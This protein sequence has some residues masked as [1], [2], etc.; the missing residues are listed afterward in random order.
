MKA[1]W[2]RK[3]LGELLQKT[4][5]TDPT[6]E[7]EKPFS[8]ID[9]SSVSNETFSITET[10]ELLGK[11][12]PSRARRIVRSGDVIF[13]T[14]RP[15]LKR[16]AIVPDE[17]DNAV[18]STGYFVL[19]GGSKIDNGYLFYWLFSDEFQ[20]E[21]ESRQKGASYPAVNDGDIRD[22]YV[23]VPPLNEQRR[24]VAV[25][26][27]AFA[28][29]ATAT[30]NAQ[31]NLT[32]ARA[33]FESYLESIFSNKDE[34]W[35]VGSLKKI[36]G[37]VSTGPFGSLLHK[38]DYVENGIPLVNPAHIVGEFIEAD[39]RKSIS[40]KT[41]SR[42][43]AYILAENDIV[44]GR[45]GE[46]GRC[47]VVTEAESGWLCGTGCFFIRPK[48][49]VKAHFLAH[50]LRSKPYR[51]KLEAMATGATMLNLSNTALGELEIALPSITSQN[52]HVIKLNEIS[53]LVGDLEG[54]VRSKL[55]ALTEL[56]QSLLNKAFAGELT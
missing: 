47:A 20:A 7:P 31:K 35:E 27:K 28:G 16:V 14:I 46:I 50:L 24:I 38:S 23:P 49:S 11:D 41:L 18:C 34:S 13:A 9:V 44:I 19:R 37:N 12:A 1:G 40:T 29:I 52:D 30:A 32:N 43:S 26:D 8:Y 2:E 36:G 54:K 21:M 51:E 33:L 53:L 5:T 45:R 25:L 55:T 4:G 22:Q 6:R 48:K 10:S 56:K 17:L 39:Y 42:L 3:R 15:T